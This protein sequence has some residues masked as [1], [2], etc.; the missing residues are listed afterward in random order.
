MAMT[1]QN[2]IKPTSSGWFSDPTVNFIYIN[3]YTYNPAAMT[4]YGDRKLHD[5]HTSLYQL[6]V[7]GDTN[8]PTDVVSRDERRRYYRNELQNALFQTIKESTA[9]HL[10]ERKST[11]N[12]ANLLLGAA[13]LGL[14]GAAAVASGTAARSLAAAATGAA[15]AFLGQ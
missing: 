6:A 12:N 7:N 1:W 2:G 10:S 15:G 14:A 9:Q 5:F 3:P 4:N 8:T 13:T 11:E